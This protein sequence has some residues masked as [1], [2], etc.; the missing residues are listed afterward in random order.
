M[1]RNSK[2]NNF[3][4]FY[5]NQAVNPKN[6]GQGVRIKSVKFTFREHHLV[7]ECRKFH[8]KE[9]HDIVIWEQFETDTGKSKPVSLQISQNQDH[10][11]SY[12]KKSSNSSSNDG[13][14]SMELSEI[15]S[16]IST[17]EGLLSQRHGRGGGSGNGIY[18]E[19]TS[20]IR[21]PF[22]SNIKVNK[23]NPSTPKMNDQDLPSNVA[24][25][26]IKH[27]IRVDVTF[28]NCRKGDVPDRLAFVIYF[29]RNFYWLGMQYCSCMCRKGRM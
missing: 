3:F 19:A 11:A 21:I 28:W 6:E 29:F 23:V 26:E 7:G 2:E 22:S 13:M 16:S 27:S 14:A 12:A 18:A 10:F 4:F 8:S 17:K 15:R 24:A 25:V 20:S 5:F 9:I 1:V